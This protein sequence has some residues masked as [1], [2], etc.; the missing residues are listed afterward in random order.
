MPHHTLVR[1]KSREGRRVRGGAPWVFSNEIE[2]SNAVKAL[3]PGALV[4][5]AVEDGRILGTGY[6]NPKS[7]IAV[8]LLSTEANAEIGKEFFVHRIGRALALREALYARPF[9]RLVHAEGDGLAGLTIDRFGDTLV[10]QITTA[11]MDALTEHLLAALDELLAPANVI[12]RNDTPV[13]A[14]EGLESEVRAAKG[15]IPSRLTVEENGVRYFADLG[16]GQKTGWYY[17]QRDNRAFVAA[18]AKGKSVLDAYCY[19]G[20][21][22]VLAAHAGAREIVGIDSSQSALV[23]AD[24]AGA[25]NGARCKFVKAD[26]FEELERLAKAN[27]KFDI[28]I[29]DPPP[30]AKARKDVEAASRAYRKL[31]RMG[32]SVTATNGFLLIASCSYN[33]PLDRFAEECAIG[34]GRTDRSASLIRQSG[35]APDHPVHPRLPETAYLKSLVY[36]LD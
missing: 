33:M 32:A 14:L 13:R 15:E 19:T 12:L 35:A 23:L 2:L 4:N 21:F 7:L 9:Y 24:E 18:L 22:G 26:V 5:V 6:F 20:G 10:V 31:A 25:A 30:F 17:D 8:R 36:A 16:H 3:T 11:G 34:I 27:E 29:C 28:V 1:L